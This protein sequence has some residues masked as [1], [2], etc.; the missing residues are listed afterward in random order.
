[1]VEQ[2]VPPPERNGVVQK[3]A[4]AQSATPG[5]STRFTNEVMHQVRFVA[6]MRDLSKRPISDRRTTED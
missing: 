6:Q 5:P 1:M 4:T 2:R 3:D